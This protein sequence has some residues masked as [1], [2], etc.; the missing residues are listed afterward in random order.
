M[1]GGERWVQSDNSNRWLLKYRR[2]THNPG[3][4]CNRLISPTTLPRHIYFVHKRCSNVI[5]NRQGTLFSTRATWPL[6][7]EA[8]RSKRSICCWDCSGL[9]WCWPKD[10][11][12]RRGRRNKSGKRLSTRSQVVQ[13]FQP[14]F[15]SH[16]GQKL[17]P[18][19]ENSGLD[20]AA[21]RWRA[22]DRPDRGRPR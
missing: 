22:G 8:R 12:V 5:R 2:F 20:L 10:F 15:F 11:S 14:E 1:G 13:Q 18:R 21:K 3:S 19:H 7:P 16:E 6:K 9:I 4:E 17:R